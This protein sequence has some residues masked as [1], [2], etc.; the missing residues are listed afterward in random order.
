MFACL[1]AWVL[2]LLFVHLLEGK[3]SGPIVVSASGILSL[4]VSCV[5]DVLHIV[6]NSVVTIPVY[7]VT[8]PL[9]VTRLVGIVALALAVHT[10]QTETL[11]LCDLFFRKILNPTVHFLYTVV[12]ALRV[13]YE[14][15]AAFFNY[16]VAVDKTMLWGSLQLITK[17]NLQLFTDIVIATFETMQLLLKSAFEFLGAGNE[18]NL[19]VNDWDISEVAKSVITIAVAQRSIVDCACEQASVLYKILV[20]PMESDYLPRTANHLANIGISLV[21][22]LL[23]SLPRWGEYPT[24]RKTFHHSQGFIH[25]LGLWLDH[26]VL[27][28]ASV[29]MEEIFGQDPILQ[30]DRPPQFLGSTLA[31][32]SQA[33]LEIVYLVVRVSIHM[34]IPLRLGDSDYVFK[35]VS[36]REIFDVHL[37]RASISLTNSLHWLLEYSWSRMMNTPAPAPE[38]NCAFTPAFYGDRIFQSFFCGARYALKAAT[39]ILA[40][41]STLPVEFV[42]HGVLFGDRNMWLMLQRYQ[43]A[44]RFDDPSLSSCEMRQASL[45][46]HSTDP[47]MCDCDLDGDVLVDRLADFPAFDREG[48]TWS[49]LTKGKSASCAQPQLE[50]AFRDLK[51]FVDHSS[52]IVSPFFKSFYATVLNGAINTASVSLRLVLSAEDVIDGEFF[53]YPLGEAGYGFRE[54]LAVAAWKSAGNPTTSPQC[55]EGAIPETALPGSPCMELSDV[56]RLHEAR[57]RMYKGE[58]LCRTTNENTGCTCNPALPML[59]NSRCSCMLTYPDDERV[60]ADSYVKVRFSQKFQA[61]GWCGSQIFEPILM[62]LEAESG[63]AISDLVDGL[64]PGAGVGWCTK[65]DYVVLETS[66]NQ[67]TKRE[68]END[69]FLVDRGRT[70]MDELDTRIADL[71]ASM[72]LA[73]EEAQLPRANAAQ[74]QAMTL[75]ATKKAILNLQGVRAL[76]HATDTCVLEENTGVA[77]DTEAFDQAFAKPPPATRADCLVDKTVLRSQTLAV[78]KEKSCTVRGNHDIVCAANAYASRAAQIYIGAARQLWSGIV[79]LLSGHPTDVT[80]DLSNRLCDLQKSISYQSSIISSLF[81]VE[82]QTRVAMNKLLFLALEFN[83]EQYSLANSGLVLLDSLVKGELFSAQQEDSGPVYEFIENVAGTYLTYGAN[84]LESV[85]DLFESF[86]KGSGEFLYSVKDFMNNF[87]SVVTDSLVKTA[88]MYIELVAE[89]IGVASGKTSEIPSLVT[90][91]LEFLKHLAVLIPKIA[92]QTL[93]L[94]LEAMGPVG[95]FLSMLVGTV[96]SMLESVINVI[97]GAV[98]FLSA[99]TAGL[100]NIDMGCLEGFGADLNATELLSDKKSMNDLPKI[101]AKLGW[102]GSSYCANVVNSYASY[103]LHALR[104][105]EKES[106]VSCLKQRWLGV[107]LSEQTGILDLQTVVYDW[108]SQVRAVYRLARASYAYFDGMN[109][110]STKTFLDKVEMSQYYPAVRRLWSYV[111][112]NAPRYLYDSANFIFDKSMDSMESAGGSSRK[113]AQVAKSSKH[114]AVQFMNHWDAHNMSTSSAAFVGAPSKMLSHWWDNKN[115]AER[116]SSASFGTNSSKLHSDAPNRDNAVLKDARRKLYTVVAKGH[117][118]SKKAMGYTFGAAGVQSN[119]DPCT[120]NSLV[121]VN[122][123]IV[124]N[125]L[126]TV[127]EEGVRVAIFLKY[128]WVDITLAQAQQ[129]IAKRA[130][131][132]QNGFT[133]GVEGLFSDISQA[134][135]NINMAEAFDRAR[136]DSGVTAKYAAQASLDAAT[137]LAKYLEFAF[138][139]TEEVPGTKSTD[140]L[141]SLKQRNK[142]YSLGAQEHPYRVLTYFERQALDWKFLWENWPSLP[143]N[144]THSRDSPV[145][146]S[147]VPTINIV[148]AFKMYLTNTDGGYVPLFGE[149]L[150]YSLSQPLLSNC[151]MGG[152]IYSETSTQQERLGRVQRAFWI[153][154]AAGI[155]IFGLQFY[156]GV[157]FLAITFLSPLAMSFLSYLFLWVVYGWGVNCNPS[158]PV[159]IAAD[160]TAFINDFMHPHPLCERFPALVADA[161]ECDSQTSIS[162]T[163]STQWRECAGDPAYDELG[164]L[165]STVYYARLLV[166]DAYHYLRTV[167]PFRYWL[168][169]FETLDLLDK[170]SELREN[171]AR[172][173]MLDVGGVV[174]LLGVGLFLVY[175]VVAPPAFALAKTSVRLSVQLVGLINLLVLSVSKTE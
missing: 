129:S 8:R 132:L 169:N 83:V 21:Q 99:G 51:R 28:T 29:T 146:A 175:N 62:D 10:W 49:S 50:D 105:I 145:P 60:V 39:G 68:W 35:L 59:D 79:A 14:P 19:F 40:V 26:A 118:V 74:L 61:R 161:D 64:H 100:E 15:F 9:F 66:M 11:N 4:V 127:V 103:K 135:I 1:L 111:R 141:N 142:A 139:S 81:P 114:I 37:R 133:D 115:S 34:L 157:P 125:V 134:R 121:C 75:S 162:F 23:R 94:I 30:A 107:K 148:E 128:T 89:F 112:N 152:V 54:D 119:V 171:C 168:S 57:L 136:V 58:D 97:V 172:L 120:E 46:D 93:G 140:A 55:R 98:N 5:V 116:K 144:I 27:E 44:A 108:H 137:N 72:T 25:N 159:M 163:G 149:P 174:S 77:L 92:M 153:T 131:Q 155:I 123:A 164:Y 3:T 106:L 160:A 48:D 113:V 87:K 96:C 33:N 85:G 32:V 151:T 53:Q 65:E 45:W 166:P 117:E 13:V 95:E 18:G 38:L 70:A 170:P 52:N 138:E 167:Q 165:Y 130:V 2:G 63:T 126:S 86:N 150:F 42:V 47:S 41:G 24:L 156:F 67:F 122:C 43:G 71:L 82:R 154:L 102:E 104:P 84:V 91:I 56:A 80:W 20:S 17:C 147:S 12:F 124:D 16:M 36:P 31:S 73:R 78:W 143:F 69:A 88:V 76:A 158:V 110:Q 101:I 109:A 6:A 173:L 7:V 90:S 22:D